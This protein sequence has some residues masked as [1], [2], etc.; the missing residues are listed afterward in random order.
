MSALDQALDDLG[1][2]KVRS[3]ESIRKA[4]ELKL[5]PEEGRECIR[6]TVPDSYVQDS[7]AYKHPTINLV[8]SAS[9]CFFHPLFTKLTL[10]SVSGNRIFDGRSRCFCVVPEHRSTERAP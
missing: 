3:D 6:G 5:S 9:G 8:N 4:P 2:L 10:Y 1:K 7:R